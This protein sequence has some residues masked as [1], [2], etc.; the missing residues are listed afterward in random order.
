MQIFFI[1]YVF[2][3]I[4][5]IH[6]KFKT[7]RFVSYLSDTK[8]MIFKIAKKLLKKSIFYSKN[9]RSRRYNPRKN[10]KNFTM[11]KFFTSLLW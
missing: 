9:I 1:N 2:K 7:I 3:Q 5:F 4:P 10:K 6:F 11:S 8:K